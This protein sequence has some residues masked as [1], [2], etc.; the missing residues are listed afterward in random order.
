MNVNRCIRLAEVYVR[1]LGRVSLSW[2]R[3]P[4][5]GGTCEALSWMRPVV[6]RRPLPWRCRLASPLLVADPGSVERAARRRS[7]LSSHH[8]SPAAPPTLTCSG[9]SCRPT[10]SA[11]RHSSWPGAPSGPRPRRPGAARLHAGGAHWPPEAPPRGGAPPG[12]APRSDASILRRCR[13]SPRPPL[14]VGAPLTPAHGAAEPTLPL[15]R[16]PASVG[17]RPGPR[18]GCRGEGGAVRRA[19]R[20][21][22]RAGGM[23]GARGAPAGPA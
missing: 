2:G 20:G 11:H 6:P 23:A 15:P 8:H 12:A 4:G 10:G 1:E 14:P 5:V 13:P 7:D 18:A 21:R 16:G 9:G 17:A 19:V 22:G 3:R